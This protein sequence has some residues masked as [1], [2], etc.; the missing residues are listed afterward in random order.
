MSTFVTIDGYK[1]LNSNVPCGLTLNLLLLDVTQRLEA[2]ISK[3]S[4][5][6]L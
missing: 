3:I 1:E 2:K 6:Y 4:A 5:V